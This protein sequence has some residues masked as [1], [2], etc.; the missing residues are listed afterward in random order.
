MKSVYI[1]SKKNKVKINIL[2]SF[3]QFIS[4]IQPSDVTGVIFRNNF[5][6]QHV[7]LDSA[8]F[9]LSVDESDEIFFL[10]HGWMESR[11]VTWYRQLTQALLNQ[12]EKTVVVQV[13]WS[14]GSQ[15]RRDEAVKN[16]K[17][18]GRLFR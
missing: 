14:K 18:T 9:S 12:Y 5:P 7:S 11:N 4:A 8:N 2:Y 17:P 16:N 13:D 6:E 1:N 15:M 3:H 10:I